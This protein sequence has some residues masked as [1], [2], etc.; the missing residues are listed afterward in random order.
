MANP[1]KAKGTRWEVSVATFLRERGFT[2]VF[3][4]APGG[5]HD[6]G[7]IGGL[8]NWAIECRDRSK[9]DL[10][11]NVRDAELRAVHKNCRWGVAILKKRGSSVREGYVVM[12]L[13]Q[14]AE[15]LTVLE[16]N[17]E[18]NIL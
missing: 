14:F 18:S 2:E 3:R 1:N 5:E 16:G 7:D 4:L 6:A 9:F 11:K 12:S 13:D 15:V 10:A 17:N 8:P